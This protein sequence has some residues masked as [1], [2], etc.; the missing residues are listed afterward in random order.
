MAYK[1]QDVKI[2]PKGLN[3]APPGDQVSEG[4]CLDLTGWW[5]SSVGKL[6]QAPGWGQRNT[7]P[8]GSAIHSISE[9]AGRTYYGAAG[10]LYQIGRNSEAAIDTGY[11]GEPLGMIGYQG[12]MWTMNRSKQSRD[13][14]SSVAPWPV[15]TPGAPS[16]STGTGESLKDGD[17]E[18]YVT[19]VDQSSYESNPSPVETLTISSGDD[20]SATITRPTAVTPA[21]IAGW[22]VYR[23]SP[24][25]AAKYKLNVN[26]IAYATT[27]YEDFGDAAHEQSDEDVIG[28]DEVLEEDHDD[29]PGARV[30]ADKPYNNRLVIAS[31]ASFPNRIWYGRSDQPAYFPA[32]QFVDVGN[33]PGDAIL[34]VSIKK[35]HFI[36]YRQRSIWWHVGDFDDEDK[37]LEPL[38]PD[39]GT[40]GMRSF[41]SSSAGNFFAWQDGIY[42]LADRADMVSVKVRPVFEAADIENFGVV[43]T[44]YWSKLALGFNNGRLWVSYASAAA[45]E[46]SDS[47][48]Y[49]IATTRWFSRAGAGFRTF[50][51]GSQFFLTGNLAGEILSLEDGLTEDGMPVP[52][53]YQSEYID[54]GLP[55]HE[56]TF[57]DLVIDH[58]TNGATLHIIIRQN[59]N[60]TGGG[61]DEF[62]IGTITSTTLTRTTLALTYPS[63]HPLEFQTVKAYN[64]SIRIEGDGATIGYATIH[65]PMLLHYYVEARRGA[66]WDSGI[67]D[68]GIEGV[69]SLS[70][71]EFDVDARDQCVVNVYSDFPFGVMALRAGLQIDPTQGRRMVSLVPPPEQLPIDGK[72]FRILVQDV[73]AL[74]GGSDTGFAVYGARVKVLP[75]G[76]YRDGSQ[77]ESWNT[78]PLEIGA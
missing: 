43:N 47:L 37:K 15:E 20:G 3:L 1:L 68:L 63:G 42:E 14:G 56:K 70:E 8:A 39:M 66:E 55:D 60:R 25:T 44:V 52:L 32:Q 9:T 40:L 73:V 78:E 64:V 7:T 28:R 74:G 12:F 4:D 26:L 5:P 62:E 17:Y 50:Y 77:G 16:S 59:K 36:I 45:T 34:G 10:G 51:R 58:Q 27:D 67:T 41:V 38:V 2:V 48:I 21:L 11:D 72:L 54:C 65:T 23:K 19:F 24:G 57:A 49:D 76:E 75:I 29:P 18:Y 46:N 13:N 71:V 31:S 6:L 35:G 30:M 33:D 22:N 61:V 69:K 53:A